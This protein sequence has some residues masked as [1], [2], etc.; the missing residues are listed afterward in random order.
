M[1]LLSACNNT[2]EKTKTAIEASA[3]YSDG[4]FINKKSDASTFSLKDSWNSAKRFLFEKDPESSPE[5]QIP[6]KAMSQQSLEAERKLGDALY[7]IGHSS[8]LLNLDQEFY[9]ID[10]VFGERASPV[11]FAGP[12]RFHATPLTIDQL[13]EI[14][15]VI[16]SHDHY[17]H[18]DKS[19]IKALADKVETFIVPLNVGK[20]LRKW[21][22]D[23]ANV[24]EL[25]WW[26]SIQVESTNTILTATPAQHFSGRTL[27]DKNET[28]WASWVIQSKHRK[29]FFSGDSG[30]FEGFK[31]IGERLGPF[32]LSLMENGAYDQAWEGVHM[33]PE[34]SVQAHID[35]QAGAL[36]PIHNSTFDLALHAWHEPLNRIEKLTHAL[37][38][39]LVTP[40]IGSRLALEPLTPTQAWWKSLQTQQSAKHLD[41]VATAL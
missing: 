20:H 27:S 23:S 26:Q 33:T 3:Q 29:I 12:K 24:V 32:D 35:L 1:V 17:D 41:T 10:P 2:P 19:S 37:N 9:L 28:L 36:L 11:S 8:L 16:I 40:T 5:T 21:G 13:P 7:R 4:V 38:I 6:V 30:Y 25:D 14:K 15:A 31:E 39:P 22:V 34:Q 18:L